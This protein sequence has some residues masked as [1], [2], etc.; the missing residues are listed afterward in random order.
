M[1]SAG[2]RVGRERRTMKVMIA[3]YCRDHHHPARG[4][5]DE[6]AALGAYAERR[7]DLCPYAPDKPTCFNCLS[8][9]YQ[10]RMREAVK[11]VMRYAGPRMMARHPILAVRHILDGRR[12][13]PARPDRRARRK[14]HSARQPPAG[15]DQP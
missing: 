3:L 7:L 1:S 9:C 14:A 15:D 5:C 10:P 11:E 8:H 4:L 2:A 12:P 13:A 6:C